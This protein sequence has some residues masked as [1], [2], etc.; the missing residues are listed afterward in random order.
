MLLVKKDITSAAG[1]LQICAGQ[2]SSAEAAIH[3]MHDIY[4]TEESEAVLLIYA[5]NSINRSVML[6]NISIICHI[7][8]TYIS[9]CYCVPARLFIISGKELLSKECTTQGDPT[10]MGADALAVTP[11]LY[12]LRD[13]IVNSEHD[14]KEVAFADDYS[15][16]GKVIEIKESIL[17]E[18]KA[19]GQVFIA[20]VQMNVLLGD[21]VAIQFTCKFFKKIFKF[22]IQLIVYF[23]CLLCYT[24]FCE[25]MFYG[26]CYLRQEF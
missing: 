23:Y 14:S 5:F 9:N 20:T 26:I 18:F 17:S 15:V 12:F 22:I 4:S 3:V 2:D 6:H 10:A 11:L 24:T 1:A 25:R 7:V 13:F 16:S 21:L 8:S 19:G